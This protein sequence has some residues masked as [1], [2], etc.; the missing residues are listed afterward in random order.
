M[1]RYEKTLFEEPSHPSIIHL[2]LGKR[3]YSLSLLLWTYEDICTELPLDRVSRV[4]ST[5]LSPFCESLQQSLA[6]DPGS[7][8]CQVPR[9][10]LWLAA[11][12]ALHPG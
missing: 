1:Q 12:K 4:S 2:F 5:L 9:V 8:V 10:T 3:L 11:C 6:P 7:C